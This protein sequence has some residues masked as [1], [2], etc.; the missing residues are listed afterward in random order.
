MT[1][2]WQVLIGICGGFFG[3]LGM[4][5]GTLLIPLLTIFLDFGQ[6]L[7]QG[8]NLVTFVVMAIFSLLI[9]AKNGM[10]ESKGIGYIIFGGL[11]F[12]IIG[13]AGATIIPSVVLRK[14]FGAFLICL[15]IIEFT[16]A[17]TMK[18]T[19]NLR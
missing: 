12:T 7:S 9:H 8:I 15:S 11:V 3:G 16:K 2:L 1:S 17:L 5:G 19:K 6:Q 18:T 13:A 14:L 4:G 10:I